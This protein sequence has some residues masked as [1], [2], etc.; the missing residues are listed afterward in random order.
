MDDCIFCMVVSGKVPS[1][2]IWEDGKH[3]AILDINPNT[4]GMTLVITKKHYDSYAFDMPENEYTSAMLAAKTVGKV[5][6]KGL[7]VKR[8]VLVAEGLGV[9]HLH[10]KLYPVH[11]LK[12]KFIETW[13]D[14]EVYFEG[15]EGYITTKLGPR[16]SIKE[17]EKV[18]EKINKN[19]KIDKS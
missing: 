15:Y 4:E 19:L 5:L 12:D 10:I 3:I 18:K 6:D 14:G 9:N 7:I 2:K 1:V 17:L 13:A 11:G 16:K 8:T